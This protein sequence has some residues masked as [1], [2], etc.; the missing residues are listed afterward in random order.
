[1]E[2]YGPLRRKFALRHLVKLRYYRCGPVAVASRYFYGLSTHTSSNCLGSTKTTGLNTACKTMTPW[3]SRTCNPLPP[4]AVQSTKFVHS[5]CSLY[6]CS[7]TQPHHRTKF[8]PR[9]HPFPYTPT[10]YCNTVVQSIASHHSL[11]APVAGA[12]YSRLP[13][14]IL[15]AK[16]CSCTVSSNFGIATNDP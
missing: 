11:S 1:M 2:H 6:E 3:D 7:E 8:V 15:M 9:D 14:T 12:F 13:K 4:L 5:V 10:V 16:R